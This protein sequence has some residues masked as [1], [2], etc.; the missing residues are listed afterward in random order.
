MP[1]RQK[2]P[3]RDAPRGIV[4]VL[5]GLLGLFAQ[6]TA[7]QSYAQGC[8]GCVP[9]DDPSGPAHHGYPLGL[10]P[11]GSNS[12]PPAHQAMALDA[13]SRVIPR[14]ASGS[15]SGSGLIGFI[16]I[17]MSN[18][19]QEFSAFELQESGRIGRN[20]RV[21]MIDCALPGKSAD[22]IVNPLEPYWAH[23]A[24][25]IAAAGLDPDQIQVAWL[26]EA[27]GAVPD[28]TFPLH[29]DTLRAH[30]GVIARHLRDLFPNLE[31]CYLASRTYG[32]YNSNPARSEPLSYE[33]GFAVRGLIEEQIAGD[34]LLNADPA[35]GPVEA[36]ALL[37]GP[38]LWANGTIPRASD[39]LVWAPGDVIFDGVHPSGSGETKVADLLRLFF[40][41]E[42]T[43][44]GWRD[45]QPTELQVGIA[46]ILDAF[47][48][49][50]HPFEN[51]G[52]RDLLAWS[53]PS[54]R[55]Y[56]LFDLAS[57]TGTPFNAELRMR[58]RPDGD[59]AGAEVV[60]VS[61][62]T[63][64]ENTITASNAPQFNGP[65]LGIIP[66]AGSGS[67]LT[68][69]VTGAVQ[70][71]L[72]AGRTKLCLGIR[73]RNG[74]QTPQTVG[75]RESLDPPRLTIGTIVPSTD[76]AVTDEASALQ[77][78]PQSNPFSPGDAIQLSLA[79]SGGALSIDLFD[80]AGR[81]VRSFPHALA[82]FG[83]R[84][85]VWDG[86]DERGRLA[87]TGPYFVRVQLTR[88]GSSR[89]LTAKQKFI[90]LRP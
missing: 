69:D 43:A 3:P 11:G 60:V 45:A 81:L 48:D 75:S 49:D 25:R 41:D 39:G 59:M 44:A 67:A 73:L 88:A 82:T 61:D 70:A 86:L 53:N 5:V 24:S 74:P 29:A 71:S 32:G 2:A 13:A 30:L 46:A 22:L 27:E 33:T 23:V 37:W 50:T 21:I 8:L 62:T 31:L 55:S 58:V 40:N 34:P 6:F 42:P 47:V 1:L 78:R 77:V 83:E 26:K 85:V 52:Q 56:L 87:P 14:D 35:V 7:G 19:T 36:P 89:P 65:I 38:Y 18:T 28:T 4:S 76:V 51:Y 57:V 63:W 16:S 84:S 66:S 10:Y 80:T 72:N 15:P 17:G 12:P 20:P 9:L 64:N 54:V 90:L 79:A 68:F